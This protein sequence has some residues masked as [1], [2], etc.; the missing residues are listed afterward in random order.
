MYEEP[1]RLVQQRLEKIAALR[2]QGVDP[3]PVAAYAPTHG[4]DAV[5]ADGDAMV[6]A[7]AKVRVAGRLVAKRGMGRLAFWDLRGGGQDLQVML[8]VKKLNPPYNE[9]LDLVTLSDIVGVEGTVIR[10]RVGELSIMVDTLTVLAKPTHPMQLGKRSEDGTHETVEDRE[11]LLRHR[12]LD[13]LNNPESRRRFIIRSQVVRHIRRYLDDA[14]FLEVETPILGN[15]Y[16]GAAARPFTTELNVLHQEMFLRISLECPLKR[17]LVGGLDKVYEL[18]R[19]FRNEGVDASHNPEFTMVEWYEAYSDYRHQMERFE[20]LVS[21]IA[22]AVHGTTKLQYKG[23]ELDLSRPWKRM[24][25]LDGLKEHAGLDLDGVAE[26]DLPALFDEHHPEGREALPAPGSW[27]VAVVELFETLV[28]PKLWQPVFVMDH[29]LD[30][31]PLTKQHREDERLVE[32]FEPFIAG[33]E[34]GNAYSE[35]NDPVEQYNRLAGQQVDREEAYDMD[36]DFVQAIA[37]GM[38]PAGGVGLGVDRV[39]ML[40]ADAESIRDVLFFPFFA[41]KKD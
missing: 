4:I 39:V 9:H 32:R 27:G 38:P 19:N 10:T 7:E 24:T 11:T 35:L 20:E 28:E 18:G 5:V 29:P 37:H 12:H 6:E 31:S 23:Q 14:G 16:S 34:I 1:G 21:G 15:S 17:L 30:I 36:Q 40:M 41:D 33:M 25:M 13:L 8:R 3:Y 26:A 22:E 2:E